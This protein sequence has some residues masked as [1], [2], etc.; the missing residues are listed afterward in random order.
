MPLY[1]Q[2]F[3]ILKARIGSG[4]LAP[5]DLLPSEHELCDELGVSR[6]T[7][8]R[9]LND[10]ADAG[11][12]V[13]ERGRG[14][15]VAEALGGQVMNAALE[16]WL[17]NVSAMARDTD[18]SV[19][20]FGYVPAT[21]A[22]AAALALPPG[23]PVQRAVRMRRLKGVPMSHLVTHVPEEIGRKY[24]ADDLGDVALLKLLE[25]AGVTVAS[26][27]QTISATLADPDVAAALEV[28]PGNPL[29]EVQRTVRDVNERPVEFIRA[30]YR[31]DVYRFAMS[32]RRVEGDDGKTWTPAAGMIAQTADAPA[33]GA[34]A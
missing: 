6:I 4:E 28:A 18:V 15:R 31:P 27:S 33:F 10:L 22:V 2:I 29:I 26:A 8:K 7:V 3:L 14:T 17:E 20:E 32:M 11:L 1:R 25:A 9:A 34:E 16:G 21:A 30:L 23:A 12:V 5:G 19:L 24:A 13:R